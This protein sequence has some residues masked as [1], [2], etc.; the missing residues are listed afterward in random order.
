MISLTPVAPIFVTISGVFVLLTLAD[1]RKQGLRAALR[2][3][4]WLRSAFIFGA[5]ALFLVLARREG[6]PL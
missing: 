5:I 1:A 3:K 4:A 6:W 2:R